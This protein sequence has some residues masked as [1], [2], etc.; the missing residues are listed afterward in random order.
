M[1]IVRG[2]EGWKDIRG[3]VGEF[4]QRTRTA[5]SL[6]TNFRLDNLFNLQSSKV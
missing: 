5:I 6:G 4:K 1:F 2:D 3:I